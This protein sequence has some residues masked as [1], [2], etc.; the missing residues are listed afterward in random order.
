MTKYQSPELVKHEF[1]AEDILIV[2]QQN[3]EWGGVQTDFFTWG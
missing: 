2:S 1:Q 3:E